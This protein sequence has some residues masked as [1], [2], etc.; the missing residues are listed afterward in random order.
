MGSGTTFN[1]TGATFIGFPFG[2]GTVTSFSTNTGLTA[3]GNGTNTINLYGNLSLGNLSLGGATSGQVLTDVGGVWTPLSPVGNPWTPSPTTLAGFNSGS[4]VATYAFNATTINTNLAASYQPLNANLTSLAGVAPNLTTVQAA[5]NPLATASLTANAIEIGNTTNAPIQVVIAN[6]SLVSRNSS[7][8]YVAPTLANLTYS[9]ATLDLASTAVSAATYGDATHVGSFTVDAKGRLTAASSI[10]IT[11]NP[12]TPA[13]STLAGFDGTGNAVTYGGATALANNFTFQVANITTNT[14]IPALSLVNPTAATSGNQLQNSP[15]LIFS[16]NVWNGTA[17]VEDDFGIYAVA[18]LNPPSLAIDQRVAGGSWVNL[19][20]LANSTMAFESGMTLTGPNNIQ[21]VL[22]I[23]G[24]A[25]NIL[26]VGIEITNNRTPSTN[27]W[28]LWGN[29][30][31]GINNTNIISGAPFILNTA[32]GNLAIT[33]NFSGNLLGTVLGVTQ[34]NGTANTT[35]ATT[36]FVANATAGGGVTP[37][38]TWNISNITSNVDI[39]ALSLVNPTAAT[40]GNQLQNSPAII[41]SGN[42]WN[43]TASVETDFGLYEVPGSPPAFALDQQIAGGGFNN[44]ITFQNSTIAVKSGMTLTGPNNIQSVLGITGNAANILGVGIEIT[45]NRTPSTNG[46]ILWG[47][48][49]LGINNTN[50]ISGAP[51]ILNTANG[52]LAITGNFSGNLLGTVLGVTQANGTANTTLATTQFVANATAGGGGSGS[53]G[54][55]DALATDFTSSNTTQTNVP[56]LSANLIAGKTYSVVC[57]CLNGNID[58]TGG[59]QIGFGGTATTSSFLGAWSFNDA[60]AGIAT[61][62][63]INGTTIPGVVAQLGASG[64]GD[65]L[66]INA[67]VVCTVNGTLTIQYSQLNTA[68]GSS[69]LVTGTTF[70]VTQQ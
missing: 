49:T 1:G 13:N 10:S 29:N 55:Y 46:W 24:N 2:V 57:A 5:L 42:Y 8:V 18:G 32:N 62:G 65:V 68:V 60:G 14:D 51:F 58:L 28:I 36:Q 23:T 53:Q 20:S 35:L 34:A 3:T 67:Q 33:G 6:S 43:G 61:Q 30:T 45:N 50:I 39:P 26:G 70:F 66:Y 44:I 25:A 54:Q 40:S 21:S 48:N 22:G 52:N 19:V 41:W 17:S 27:G 64:T 12:W 47:N 15:A 63:S 56:T 11:S 9:T 69:S 4:S 59:W 38:V 37:P 7:G 16:G 31:L